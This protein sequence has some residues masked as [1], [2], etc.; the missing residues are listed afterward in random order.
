MKKTLLYVLVGAI[1]TVVSGTGSYLLTAKKGE[2][3]AAAMAAQQENQNKT[4]IWGDDHTDDDT[5]DSAFS[6][7]LKNV[8][9]Y[10]DFTVGKNSY[11]GFKANSLMGSMFQMNIGDTEF[12]FLD[13]SAPK[14]QGNIG[15]SYD[16]QSSNVQVNYDSSSAIYFTYMGGKFSV[17]VNADYSGIFDVVNAVSKFVPAPSVPETANLGSIDIGALLTKVE[18]IVKV[19]DGTDTV[20]IDGTDQK[21]FHILYDALTVDGI[22]VSNIAV[23]LTH[24]DDNN[25]TGIYTDSSTPLTITKG[26]QSFELALHMPLT[27][28]KNSSVY[29]GLSDSEKSQFTSVDNLTTSLFTTLGTYA[30]NS[31]FNAKVAIGLSSDGT[32]P[33]EAASHA[34]ELGIAGDFSSVAAVEDFATKGTYQLKLSDKV[35]GYGEQGFSAL[36]SNETTYLDFGDSFKGKVENSA[37]EDI[38]GYASNLTGDKEVTD[39]TDTVNKILAVL[40]NFNMVGSDGKIVLPASLMDQEYGLVVEKKEEGDLLNSISFQINTKAFGLGDGNVKIALTT[41]TDGSFKSVQ[42]SGLAYKGYYLTAEVSFEEFT[43]STIQSVDAASYKSLN[44]VAP[45]FSSVSGLVKAKQF[46]VGYAVN[47]VYDGDTDKT[48]SLTGSIDG[49]L[50]KLDTSKTLFTEQD[51]GSYHLSANL[52][53]SGTSSPISKTFDAKFLNQNLY[54][55]YGGLSSFKNK[56]SG[57][58]IQKAIGLMDDKSET[59]TVSD[60]IGTMNSILDGINSSDYLSDDFKKLVDQVK[61]GYLGGELQSFVSVSVDNADTDSIN[62]ELNLPLVFSNK[63]EMLS[64][65]KKVTLTLSASSEKFTALNATLGYDNV[66]MNVTMNL[67]D[68]DSSKFDLD[69][70]ES[71]YVLLDHPVASFL[72]LPTQLQK[73]DLAIEGSVRKVS[74]T[75][76]RTLVSVKGNNSFLTSDS[77]T[78]GDGY[79]TLKDEAGNLHR[80]EY[81]YIPEEDDASNAAYAG[82]TVEYNDHMHILASDKSVVRIFDEASKIS[83]TKAMTTAMKYL[84]SSADSLAVPEIIK[85]GDLS[86]ILNAAAFSDGEVTDSKLT[87]KVSPKVFLDAASIE[88]GAVKDDTS[89]VLTFTYDPSADSLSSA[90]IVMNDLAGLNVDFTL[91]LGDY[92]GSGYTTDTT[93]SSD[94]KYRKNDAITVYT[95]VS[96]VDE[97]E[98]STDHSFEVLLYS[99]ADKNRFV[100]FA[101]VADLLQMGI[102][103]T[104]ESYYYLTGKVSI[105]ASVGSDITMDAFI[106]RTHVEVEIEDGEVRTYVALSNDSSTDIT[107]EGF[108][109]S[110]FFLSTSRDEIY[111]LKTVNPEGG[112]NYSSSFIKV[113]SS[114]LNK[115]VVYYLMEY[116]LNFRTI[117]G[118]GV[119]GKAIGN[120]AMANVYSALGL[121]TEKTE[122]T[123]TSSETS[124]GTAATTEETSSSGSSAD[125]LF[126]FSLTDDYSQIFS[127]AVNDTTSRYMGLDLDLSKIAAFSGDAGSQLS[128]GHLLINAYYEDEDVSSAKLTSIEIKGRSL[129]SNGDLYKKEIGNFG[130]LV[131]LNVAV[132]LDNHVDVTNKMARYNEFMNWYDSSAEAQNLG[133]FEVTGYSYSKMLGVLTDVTVNN[134]GNVLTFGASDTNTSDK[135]YYFQGN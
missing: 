65:L 18:K 21:A 81:T 128:L 10:N 103:T 58:T 117:L 67:L 126:N 16:G 39:T 14:I 50:T 118:T 4:N 84:Q 89:V 2:E 124:T 3:Y 111:G 20:T 134:N 15:L 133:D 95:T 105:G 5:T 73:F 9:N 112:A 94:H 26:D 17:G 72:N 107:G 22:T 91:S 54:F 44:M 1:T 86:P 96:T 115:N 63:I 33:L 79:M 51:D 122:E 30:K 125:S 90:S 40:K 37:I 109:A 104:D 123:E 120:L 8:L 101:N 48:Y 12:N 110:E 19:G 99:A 31:N 13:S 27:M 74:E 119:G 80:L 116:A 97:K 83:S 93:A 108:F 121:G 70:E 98:V 11:V 71:S 47:A 42:I 78:N 23:Y 43:A 102:N 56:I 24:D 32:A 28:A 75:D 88:S 60:S 46:S 68:F 87:V 129:D 106:L 36:Y 7:M 29:N 62:V 76:E 113:A 49:D 82:T 41:G 77:K 25:L 52:S 131:S 66:S 69:G 35:A 55:E 130:G 61:N 34:I 38:I 100:S 64:K 114:E 53:S 59:T 135:A 85:D 45:I 57:S 132:H 92:A 6:K 127:S